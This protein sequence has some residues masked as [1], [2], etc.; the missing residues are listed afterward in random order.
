METATW[1]PRSGSWLC[2]P[3]SWLKQVLKLK[4]GQVDA[5]RVETATM[6][7]KIRK[8]ALNLYDQLPETSTLWTLLGWAR[9]PDGQ[10]Q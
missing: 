5:F 8:L 7:A 10:N 2:T 1:W 4:D 3:S 9:N 6:A